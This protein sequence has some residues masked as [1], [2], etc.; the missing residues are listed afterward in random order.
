MIDGRQWNLSPKTPFENRSRDQTFRIKTD[1][2]LNNFHYRRNR[3][4]GR[5]VQFRRYLK[6]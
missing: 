1:L 3:G 5:I 2:I 4:G 6:S